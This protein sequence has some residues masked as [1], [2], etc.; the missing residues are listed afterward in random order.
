MIHGVVNTEKRLLLMNLSDGKC[1]ICGMDE[2]IYHLFVMCKDLDTIWNLIEK[3][4]KSAVCNTFTLNSQSKVI[5]ILKETN[6]VTS[7]LNLN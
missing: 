1:H 6:E 4:T 2:D 3:I 5:G 7:I